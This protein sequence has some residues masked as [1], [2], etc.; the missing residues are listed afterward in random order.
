MTKITISIN[1][2]LLVSD[3]EAIREYLNVKYNIDLIVSIDH[4]G[5][6]TVKMEDV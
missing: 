6:T 4:T 2:S 5:E 3:I 1:Q